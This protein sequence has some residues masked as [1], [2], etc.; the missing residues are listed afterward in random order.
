MPRCLVGAPFSVRVHAHLPLSATHIP[1]STPHPTHTPPHSPGVQIALDVA[2]A[3]VYLHS[4]RIIHLDIK[5]ANVLLTRCGGAGGCG[6]CRPAALPPSPVPPWGWHSRPARQRR[7]VATKDGHQGATP[8]FGRTSE[9]CKASPAAPPALPHAATAP[10]R[11]ATWAWPRSWRGTTYQEWWAP[12]PGEPSQFSH[13]W[14]QSLRTHSDRGRVRGGHA[15]PVSAP[16]HGAAG[17]QVGP[18]RRLASLLLPVRMPARAAGGQAPQGRGW[19]AG[20]RACVSLHARCLLLSALRG[21]LPPCCRSAPELLL[22]QRC[23]EKADVYSMGVV[24]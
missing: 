16:P 2:R 1:H 17:C 14:A 3:L 21:A 9:T 4:R 5:S 8:C 18:P 15:G 11:W 23:T 22:G 24:L 20:R 12:W 7:D 6:V 19:S 13:W 10:P